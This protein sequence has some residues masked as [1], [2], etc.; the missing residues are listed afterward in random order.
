MTV[1]QLK[2]GGKP[3]TDKQLTKEDGAWAGPDVWSHGHIALF[4]KCP[5][6]DHKDLMPTFLESFE[7]VKA[8]GDPFYPVEV[9]GYSDNRRVIWFTDG[10]ESAVFDGALVNTIVK[11]APKK[12]SPQFLKVDWRGTPA[13]LVRGDGPLGLLM[14]IREKRL[15]DPDWTFKYTGDLPA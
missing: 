1:K 3:K 11:R 15:S 4:E 10:T 2:L 5:I 13:L 14:P 9:W 7:K 6:E 12:G 8:G